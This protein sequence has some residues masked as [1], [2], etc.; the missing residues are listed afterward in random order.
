MTHLR[1]PIPSPAMGLHV[2][3]KLV[4]R[5]PIPGL[6]Q[7]D[8]GSFRQKYNHVLK[9]LSETLLFS[10]FTVY[11]MSG[12]IAWRPLAGLRQSVAYLPSS[13]HLISPSKF[14]CEYVLTGLALVELTKILYSHRQIQCVCFSFTDWLAL[15]NTV[16]SP[17]ECTP[18]HREYYSQRVI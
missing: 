12:W 8:N 2:P 18:Q 11:T 9:T 4:S 5:N 3:T 17:I 14:T 1:Y 15:A 16:D 7:I 10:K 6:V 13:W